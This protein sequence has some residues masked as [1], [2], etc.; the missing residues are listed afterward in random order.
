MI[1]KRKKVAFA[2]VVGWLR[3]KNWRFLEF[4]WV[5]VAGRKNWAFVSINRQNLAINQKMLQKML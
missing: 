2:W 5:G 1:K 4:P 3:R